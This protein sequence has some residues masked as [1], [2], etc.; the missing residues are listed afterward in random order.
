MSWLEFIAQMSDVWAWPVVATGTIVLLRKQIKSAANGLVGRVPDLRRLKGP[1]GIDLE[2]NVRELAASTAATTEEL[3]GDASKE[4]PA[5]EP[6]DVV[7]PS[8]TAGE[9][10]SKYE[11][12]AQIDPR[13]AILL[14]FSDL[15][16]SI[17]ERFRQLYPDFRPNV[18]F[19][20]IVRRLHQDGRLND[21]IADSLM[22]M[23]KIRNQVAHEKSDLDLDVVDYFL[24]SVRNTIR[25]LFLSGFYDDPE[26][27]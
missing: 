26:V 25:N 22:Q 27:G 3:R 2:F 16:S 20:Q 17:R 6:E 21:E 11:Q 23:S 7:L 15:E 10:L 13:A 19:V 9:R 12:L 1:G 5:A 4:L 24:A 8:E 18:S 14:P